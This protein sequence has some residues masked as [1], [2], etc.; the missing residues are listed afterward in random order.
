MRCFVTRVLVI[1]T[2]CCLRLCLS[3]RVPAAMSVRLSATHA[4][5][6]P[7]AAAES[8]APSRSGGAGLACALGEPPFKQRR[9]FSE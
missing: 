2:V 3:V 4:A 9:F 7:I 5:Y 6:D 8:K 1:M